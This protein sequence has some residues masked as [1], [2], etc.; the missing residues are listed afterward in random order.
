MFSHYIYEITPG[1]YIRLALPLWSN[2]TLINKKK[3]NKINN[4]MWNQLEIHTQAA[5]GRKWEVFVSRGDLA[6]Q[7]QEG[8]GCTAYL[9]FHFGTQVQELE[10]T[11]CLGLC[12]MISRSCTPLLACGSTAGIESRPSAKL[13]IYYPHISKTSRWS[14]KWLTFLG[15]FKGEMIWKRLGTTDLLICFLPHMN[16]NSIYDEWKEFSTTTQQRHNWYKQTHAGRTIWSNLCT[17]IHKGSQR[18]HA[19]HMWRPEVVVL[20]AQIVDTQIK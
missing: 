16:T 19:L 13:Y 3:W 20:F 10:Q 11:H 18:R 15:I 4:W 12:R 8:T 6:N 1:L 5:P 14:S 2:M 9:G 17:T 7:G